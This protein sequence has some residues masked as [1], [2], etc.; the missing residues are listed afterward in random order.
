VRN[1]VGIESWLSGEVFN[2]LIFVNFR[3]FGGFHFP[4]RVD[5]IKGFA[6]ASTVIDRRSCNR[7][8]SD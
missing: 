6:W 1:P 7:R 4:C 8:P 3:A 2:S 5:G